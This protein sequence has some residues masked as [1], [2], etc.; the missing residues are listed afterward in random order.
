L[1]ARVLS[2][3]AALYLEKH[4][5]VHRSDG[6]FTF[7]DQETKQLRERLGSA[8]ARLT[9]FT[10]EKGVVSAQ[11]ERDLTLRKASELEA[12]LV[13][14]RAAIAETERRI[15]TLKQQAALIPPRTTTQLRTAD[16][17]QLLQQMKS[18]LLQLELKRTELLSKFE[19]TYRPVQDLEKQISDTRAAIAGEEN[20]PIRDE[21]TDQ[22]STY[23]WVKSELAKAR[24]DLSGLKARA[25]ANETAL[26]KY[27]E[28]A[29]SLQQASVVQEDLQRTAKT[30]EENYLLYLRK[31][32]E[33]RINDALDRRGILNV[34]IADPPTVPALPSRSIWHYALLGVLLAG[35]ASV[36]LA[37][38]SDFMDPSFRTPDEVVAL[39][40]S[41]VLASLPKNGR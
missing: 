4:L 40:D 37:F 34:G 27:S 30:Q 16:N 29:R 1:A 35:T 10:R 33:A 9:D 17:P 36:G 31:E 25:T 38:L 5:Q 11:L 24:T 13:Q 15:Q 3:V 28:T 23:E 14:T 22:N 26:A 18:T 12:S 39:L 2:S 21:T 6:E 32:E 41:P 8:E 19:P 7:F 20:A